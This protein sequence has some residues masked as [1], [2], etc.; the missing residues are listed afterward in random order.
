[1]GYLPFKH[2][3]FFMTNLFDINSAGVGCNK[4]IFEYYHVSTTHPL[5]QYDANILFI[6]TLTTCE[7]YYII[8]IIML[9]IFLP[10]CYSQQTFFF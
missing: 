9:G 6:N 2:A 8:I 1:M 4:H 10:Y 7:L 5:L 3:T